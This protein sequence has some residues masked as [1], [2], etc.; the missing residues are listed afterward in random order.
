MRPASREIVTADG[1]AERVELLTAV[2]PHWAPNVVRDAGPAGVSGGIHV[3][4]GTLRREHEGVLA[5][6]T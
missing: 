6:G 1:V 3:D 5:A 2:P 4:P